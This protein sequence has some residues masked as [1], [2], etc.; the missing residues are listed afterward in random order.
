VSDASTEL[1]KL[2]R[3]DPALKFP[4]ENTLAR[5]RR[6]EKYHRSDMSAGFYETPEDGVCA[7]IP[8]LFGA[9][10]DKVGIQYAFIIP[11][12]GYLYVAYYGLWGH[13]PSRRELA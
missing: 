11:I 8:L 2:V 10:A 3:T 5:L 9:M 1:L 13:K 4:F 7:V 12:I 6:F